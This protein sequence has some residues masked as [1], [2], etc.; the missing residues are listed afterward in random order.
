MKK[1]LSIICA[2]V[3]AI[4]AMCVSAF[5]AEIPEPL[6]GD[7]V[8]LA[9]ADNREAWEGGPLQSVEGL[10]QGSQLD[11]E[12]AN[13][14]LEIV[15]EARSGA[16]NGGVFRCEP[17]DWSGSPQ[18]QVVEGIEGNEGVY[19]IM[20]SVADF[21]N[22]LTEAGLDRTSTMVHQGNGIAKFLEARLYA[23][24]GEGT[25]DIEAMNA[26]QNPVEDTPV[27]TPVED[28]PVANPDAEA[29]ADEAPA[30]E[31][32]ET[33]APAETGVAFALIPAIIAMAVVAFKKR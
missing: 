25:P 3:L 6:T 9:T 5:A 16:A 13:Q 26:P 7:W 23:Y 27:D 11:P 15:V 12:A 18:I 28:T 17:N 24:T 32:P 20:I 21:V 19:T 31:T 4:S 22:Q 30:D 33:E 1:T 8:L 10:V 2:V 29:P 14:Y